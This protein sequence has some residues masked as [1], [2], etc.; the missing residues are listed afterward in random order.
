M[1][2]K[3]HPGD[4][5]I[6][7]IIYMKHML[8]RETTYQQR[9]VVREITPEELY[10][11]VKH[12]LH[13]SSCTILESTPP[14]SI[15][16]RFPANNPMVQLGLRDGNP[17][18][19][20]VSVGSFGNSA[21]M[22]ITFTQEIP[23]MGEAGFLYWGER[24][25]QLYRELGVPLDPYT[26]TQLYPPERVHRAISRTLRLYAFF[27]LISLAA[28]YMG[29]KLNSDMVATYFFVVVLPGTF[30]A[31]MDINDH[32]DLLKKTGNK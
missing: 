1:G 5:F 25:E 28:I 27:L 22:N 26:L 6:F 7:W 11:T 13:L 21:T 17:K 15:K 23:R 24:L 4:P 19:I 32:R 14:E 9:A 12:W 30:M 10:E 31:G 18:N 2:R 3:T 20:E 16:A 29:L 8:P